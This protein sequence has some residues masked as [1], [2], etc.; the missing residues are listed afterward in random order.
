MKE[1]LVETRK[2]NELK[3]VTVLKTD[4]FGNSNAKKITSLDLNDP[5]QVDM[6]LN[7]MTEAD[8][9]LN[10]CVGKV[11][12]VVGVNI[13]EFTNNTVNEETGENII[14]YKHPICL[15]D[16]NGK[17]YV[18]GSSMCYFSLMNIISFK[19]M[20]TKEN[21]IKVEVIKVPSDTKG[22]EYL[23]LKYVK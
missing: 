7:S 9:K 3:N 10:D 4:L 14:R 11:I 16:E 1:E 2:D 17:S 22:H 8:F 19:G 18:S 20:P 23:K 15:F 6:L 13:S 21:P 12:T 5:D